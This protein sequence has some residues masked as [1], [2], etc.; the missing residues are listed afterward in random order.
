MKLTKS[1]LKEIIREELLKEDD[2][3]SKYVDMLDDLKDDFLKRGT[4]IVK[5]LNQQDNITGTKNAKVYNKLVDK[6]FRKFIIDAKKI[7]NMIKD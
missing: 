6:Y 3:A 1:Q 5:M 2:F 4:T 7:Q